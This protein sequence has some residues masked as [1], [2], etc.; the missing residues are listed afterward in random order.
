MSTEDKRVVGHYIGGQSVI[1]TSGREGGVYNPATNE[2]IRNV[3]LAD[4]AEVDKAVSNAAE[5]FHDWA[6][7]P[8]AR[9]VQVLYRYRELL[10]QNIDE[11]A[12]LLSSE[13][14]KTVDDA[15]GS[16]TRGLEVVEFA[17]GIPQLLKGEFSE[18]VASGV[19]S[20]SMRQPLGVVAGITPFNFP[21]MVPMW[22]F[23]VAIACGNTFVLKPSE[24]NP[25]CAAFMANLLTEAGLPDGV[26]NV[27]NGDKEA[28]DSLLSHP[29]VQAVSFVG[30]TAVGE[31]VYQ[32][33]CAHG[34]RVQ[35]LCG[36]KNHMVV[37]PDA[38]MGQVVDAV[39]GAAYGS[40][41]ERCMAI[42]VVVAVGEDTADRMMEQLVPRIETL[43]VGAYDQA[44]VEMGP[45]ITPDAR[46]R[47]KNYIDRGVE[48]GADLVVDGRNISIPGY[49]SGCFVGATVFDRVKPEMAIYRDEIFGPV[50]SV[51]RAESYEAA[52]KLVN[53]H[54][55]GNGTA[56]FTRDG[57]AARDFGHRAQIGMVGVNVPIPVPLA[58][59]SFGGWK[60]SLF[61]D[62]FMH[63]PEGVRFYTRMKTLTSRWPSGIK[64][65]AVFNFKAGGEH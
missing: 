39:M 56:I 17:C 47:I 16:I 61:G 10:I 42:S 13:H 4:A 25:S 46:D 31:Y 1:G 52:L 48:E 55:Y 14:G 26:L 36:A 65:G 27:V 58:F 63:G 7:M 30:S 9:R 2:L 40:A 21:A 11:M 59:H 38:D 29:S 62:H 23:P 35:A 12:R 5:A 64:E 8:P 34:K 28:V 49:E 33:G 32:T 3:A 53:D 54:E 6:E 20:W 37:M 24:R 15:K 51:V 18:S 22:M 44:G 50:L 19:D 60:R 57:D 41:G 43:K 45:V